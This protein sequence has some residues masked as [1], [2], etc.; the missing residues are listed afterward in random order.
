[1][2]HLQAGLPMSRKEKLQSPQQ[3][4]A[5]SSSHQPVLSQSPSVIAFSLKPGH[6]ENLDTAVMFSV[7]CTCCSL[8]FSQAE[9]KDTQQMAY[10]EIAV[11][12]MPPGHTP[13]VGGCVLLNLPPN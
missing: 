13:A 2:Y 10:H 12:C 4:M 3:W 1:M 9:A 7:V 8:L 11:L 5:K 6:L